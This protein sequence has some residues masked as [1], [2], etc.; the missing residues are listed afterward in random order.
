LTIIVKCH[1]IKYAAFYYEERMIVRRIIVSVSIAF[2]IIRFCQAY[3]EIS[4]VHSET[5]AEKA[6]DLSVYEAAKH[7]EYDKF[8]KRWDAYAAYYKEYSD[9]TVVFGLK[10]GGNEHSI[11]YPP[12]IYTWIREENNTDTKWAVTG[13]QLLVNGKVYSADKMVDNTTD[14]YI[15]LDSDIGKDLLTEIIKGEELDFKL[16]YATGSHVETIIGDDYAEIKQL[17]QIILENNAWAYVLDGDGDDMKV[18]DK[19][20]SERFPIKIS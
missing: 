3:A 6:F 1:I 19:I 2:I 9:A 4:P 14:S 20:I 17:A 10:V 5:E 15:L 12:F 11:T 7:Y 16:K 18:Y 13:I 8:D